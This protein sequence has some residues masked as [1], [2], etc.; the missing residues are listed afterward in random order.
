VTTTL[1]VV[2]EPCLAPSGAHAAELSLPACEMPPASS[3][4][5]L[6]EVIE[7]AEPIVVRRDPRELP[8]GRPVAIDRSAIEA[9]SALPQPPD[10]EYLGTWNDPDAWPRG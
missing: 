1:H 8:R 5:V 2:N 3:A 10:D 6:W 9:L 4:L 7:L